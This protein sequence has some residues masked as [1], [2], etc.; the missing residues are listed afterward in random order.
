M[1]I[2]S[3]RVY[4]PDGPRPAAVIVHSGIIAEIAA[5]D[6]PGESV[7]LGSDALLPGLVDTHVHI[8]EPGR[9]D[10][11]GFATATAA[12]AA[13]GV[14][15]L[16]DMPL[17]SIPSTVD[18][19]ALAAKRA[20]AA[21][22]C[23]VDVGFWGGAVP[24]NL[25]DLAPLHEAGVFGFKCFLA[26]S[27]VDE[28]PQLSWPEL[29]P[30]LAELH[31]LDALLIV[32]AEDGERLGADPGGPRYADFEASRPPSVEDTAVARLAGL[33]GT[34][35]AR[36]H[37]LHL[38]SAS[39]VP[40]LSAARALGA[41]ITAETCPHYL[42]LH[43]EDVP[44]GATQYKCCPPI[45][46]RGNADA[47]WQAL[48]DG[49]VSCVVSDHSP[50]PAAL[51]AGGDFG[52]AWGGISSVQLGLSTVWTEAR[53]R[54]VPLASV[55]RWMAREPARLV[56]LSGK[57]RIEVGA[58]AD[59]VAFAPEEE[60]TVDPARLK[61]RHPVTPYAGKRLAGV[62]RQTWLAGEPVGDQPRGQLLRREPNR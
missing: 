9:T 33:V 2:R 46:G 3:D 24:G 19:P 36:V 6:V 55:V 16:I 56:G 12:A 27:G 54:G 21:G 5:R 17:N 20:A 44:D 40:H 48:A 4:L 45:R 32:H 47:L 14:T 29:E 51:K 58:A 8:N 31:R 50:A 62:V 18:V 26:P 53:R 59:L 42:T 11:E 13:G 7:D 39:A 28:F 30:V 61:H 23:F 41:P 35:G 37:V 34:V 15:T 25:A 60:F 49:P 52:T 38:S 1:I 43:A 57:G 22:K 10:W